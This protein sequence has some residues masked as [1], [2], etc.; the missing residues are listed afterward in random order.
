MKKSL[1]L[2]ISVLLFSLVA[3][4]HA[5]KTEDYPLTVHV[6]RTGGS[7]IGVEYVLCLEVTSEGRKLTLLSSSAAISKEKPIA[8]KTG[9]YKARILKEDQIN[10]A[11]YAREYEFLLG[12]GKKLKFDLIGESE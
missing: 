9:D 10:A 2:P 4:A 12:D 1:L 5:Q 8:M 6:Y 11:Q 3:S 7:N